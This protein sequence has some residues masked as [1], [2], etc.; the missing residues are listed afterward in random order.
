MVKEHT[1]TVSL[2]EFGLSKYEAR[3][4][5]TLISKGTL[6]ASELAYY[7]ELP[8]TKVYP[9]LLKLEKKKLVIISKS[10]PIMCTAIAPE[11]AFDGIIHEQINKVNAMNT[12]VTNLKQVS[13]ESKKARGSEEKRYFHLNAN[14]VLDQLRLMIEGSKNSIQIIVDQW[15][16]NLLSE[17]KEQLLGVL[18]RDID[19]KIIVPPVLIGNESFRKIPEGA[20]LRMSDII[21]NCLIFDQTEILIID[22][23]NGKGAIFSATDV[24]AGNQTVFFNH[25]WKNSMKTDSLA[26]MNKSEAQ[27]VCRIINVI[28][29]NGLGYVLSLAVNSKNNEIDLLQLLEKNGINLKSKTFSDMLELID[30]SLQVTCSGHANYDAN[31]KN[32]TIESK[33]NSGHS[34]PWASLLERFLKNKGYK[35]RMVVQTN[36]NKGERVHI[37]FNSK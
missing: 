32:I 28:N 37:K 27:E 2:E 5:V 29:E 6:S 11:D 3:A 21:Q 15:G 33:M 30:S 35:T 25:L 26:D 34:L 9:I 12:L 23:E 18:R 17:C 24:L 36:S 8:R 31:H 16:L 7:S 4:Y 20:K 19:V 14:N 1:L 13:E 22:N 10:K